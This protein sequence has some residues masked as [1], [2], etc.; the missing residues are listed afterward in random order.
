VSEESDGMFTIS[1]IVHDPSKYARVEQDIKLDPKNYTVYTRA[2]PEPPTD[3]TISEYLYRIG[4][5]VYSAV[6]LGWSPP[7]DL[8]NAVTYEVQYRRNNGNWIGAG[9]THATSI[10]IPNVESGTR[11]IRVRANG[12]NGLNSGWQE[13]NFILFGLKAPPAD[14]QNFAMSILGHNANLSW[15]QNADLDLSYYRIKFSPMLVGATWST[16]VDILPKITGASVQVPAQVGTYLIKAVDLGGI[17]SVN[18]SLIITTVAGLN[19]LNAVATINDANNWAG[20][21]SGTANINGTLQL[22][23]VDTIGDWPSFAELQTLGYGA[24]GIRSSGTYT[25]QNTFDLGAVYTS[26]VSASISAGGGNVLNT[27]G[28]WPSF[29]TMGTFGGADPAQFGVQVQIRTTNDDPSGTPT[30]SGWKNLIIGDYTAR[31]FQFAVVLR[32]SAHNVTPLVDSLTVKIDMPDRT[33]SA[34]NAVVSATGLTVNFN[35]A[36]RAVP[37]VGLTG[38]NLL[39]GDYFEYAAV[40]TAYGFSGVWRNSAGFAVART[41]DWIAVGYGYA[42]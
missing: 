11:T 18:A 27:I 21:H 2:R 38:Q 24:H 26:R 14:V 3:L 16:A 30:W 1:A 13:K 22:S 37:A 4:G 5:I 6:T 17:E 8:S 25:F 42:S 19:G 15:D 39:T 32:S 12:L 20:S 10:D 35:P 29:A 31:A 34:S 36:F 9:K 33:A 41:M 28:S 40:P 7:A 23:S